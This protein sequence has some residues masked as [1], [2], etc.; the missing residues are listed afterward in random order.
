MERK[1][2]FRARALSALVL[3]ASLA[4][5]PAALAGGG[6]ITGGATEITQL[7]N[8]A[9]LVASYLQQVQTAVNT[10][11]SYVQL[12]KSLKQMDALTLARMLGFNGIDQLIGLYQ[13][14]SRLQNDYQNV[15]NQL[16]N[17]Q[18]GVQMT[19][20]SPTQYLQTAAVAA[21]KY[22]G[23]YQQIYQQEQDALNSL[24]AD[25]ATA[26]ATAAS[27]GAITSTVGGLQAI[28]SS[29]AQMQ[30]IMLSMLGEMRKASMLAAQDRVRQA[31]DIKNANDQ[32]L[33]RYQA[34]VQNQQANVQNTTLPDPTT[35]NINPTSSASGAK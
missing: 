16:Q 18:A 32:A 24:I 17:F 2:P 25:Q 8:H 15:L 34:Y 33:A 6:G 13:Q 26:A 4:A 7:A 11:G 20:M 22:G 27:A 19:G 28:V 29:N 1:L 10:L 31:V 12:V 30:S 14:V 3:S 21:Q 5:S 23:I 35:F 9:E